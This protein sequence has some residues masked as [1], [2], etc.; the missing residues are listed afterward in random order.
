MNDEF[1]LR[2]K[3]DHP[4]HH[5]R[6]SD[7]ELW[8][9]D[10]RP[11]QKA[12]RKRHRQHKKDLLWWNPHCA[13][14]NKELKDY[15]CTLDHVIPLSVGGLD[16]RENLVLS[17]HNCNAA[18]NARTPIEWASDILRAQR[19]VGLTSTLTKIRGALEQDVTEGLRVLSDDEVEIVWQVVSQLT[20]E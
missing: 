19:V 18:K 10:Q 16:T 13:Y 11:T 7:P 5:N 20:A 17:C 12:K 4:F 1:F 15:S 2:P 8:G 14:C 9:D 6:I 3:D